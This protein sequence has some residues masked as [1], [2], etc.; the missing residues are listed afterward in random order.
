MLRTA[1][2]PLLSNSAKCLGKAVFAAIPRGLSP[3]ETWQSPQRLLQRGGE[4]RILSH[5]EHRAPRAGP[6]PRPSMQI[7]K[8]LF[9]RPPRAACEWTTSRVWEGTRLQGQGTLDG[10]LEKLE[11]E[12][13]CGRRAKAAASG[14]PS[15]PGFV[16]WVSAPHSSHE[17]EGTVC[18]WAT[19]VVK[20]RHTGTFH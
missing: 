4:W 10:D 18:T 16:N 17:A 1:F 8:E 2:W 5:T 14:C 13:E 15:P 20:E 3:A 11:D 19:S 7:L 6:T 12:K 9:L